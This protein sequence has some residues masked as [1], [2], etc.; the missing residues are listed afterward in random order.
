MLLAQATTKPRFKDECGSCHETAAKLVRDT[1]E[2][3]DGV[4]YSRD[5]GDPVRRFLNH[6]RDLDLNDVEFF[7]QLLTRVAHEIYR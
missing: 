2:L 4:L 6:H 7:V 1:L 5:S 3:R